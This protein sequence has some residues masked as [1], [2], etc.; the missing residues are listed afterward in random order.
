MRKNKIVC[1]VIILLLVAFHSKAQQD[2][3]KI[4]YALTTAQNKSEVI[5]KDTIYFNK[6]E[7]PSFF[8]MNDKVFFNGKAIYVFKNT[9]YYQEMTYIE[10]KGNQYLY[11]FPVPKGHAGPGIFEA[12]AGVLIR[13]KAVPV[14]KK[15]IPYYD[16]FDIQRTNLARY[17]LK[18]QR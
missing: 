15:N 18:K 7:Q 10:Q 4:L 11:I 3:G 5:N 14:I 16:F 6:P 13:V 1:L 12:Y 2:T 9:G 8:F 17:F